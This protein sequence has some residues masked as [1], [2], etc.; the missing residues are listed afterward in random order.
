MAVAAA[1]GDWSYWE[2]LKSKKVQGW[3]SEMDTGDR[4]GSGDLGDRKCH[5]SSLLV[6]SL[7][8]GRAVEGSG[9]GMRQSAAAAAAVVVVVAAAAAVAVAVVAAV[10]VA[11]ADP[12]SFG[13]ESLI[14]EGKRL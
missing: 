2:D 11:V 5:A 1:V 13:M 7:H 6:V 9:A 10:A 14:E 3:G 12:W 8:F 4:M